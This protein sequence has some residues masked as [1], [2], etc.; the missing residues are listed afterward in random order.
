M[1]HEAGA[2]PATGTA[3]DPVASASTSRRDVGD[4]AFLEQLFKELESPFVWGLLPSLSNYRSESSRWESHIRRLRDVLLVADSAWTRVVIHLNLSWL[5]YK[6]RPQL[7][8]QSRK[9][10]E[11]WHYDGASVWGHP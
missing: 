9:K 6:V 1:A 7:R 2:A 8:A 10:L 3:A 4:R 5:Y 11:R